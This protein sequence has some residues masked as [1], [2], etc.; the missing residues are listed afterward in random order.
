MRKR[1]ATEAIRQRLTPYLLPFL[2]AAPDAGL[3]GG[4]N[5]GVVRVGEKDCWVALRRVWI[6]MRLPLLLPSGRRRG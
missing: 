3:A 5:G 6:V 1:A 4:N 2:F